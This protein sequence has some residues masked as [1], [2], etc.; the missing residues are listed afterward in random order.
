MFAYYWADGLSLRDPGRLSPESPKR[1]QVLHPEKILLPS[2]QGLKRSIEP[3]G[4]SVLLEIH[5]TKYVSFV[6][7]AA[8]RGQ[9]FLD[10]GDTVVTDNIYPD[11]LLAASSGI[12]ALEAMANEGIQRAFC[13]VRPPGH[14]A[15][16]M[17]AL[18]FCVFNNAAIAARFAQKILGTSRVLIVDWDVHPGNGTEEIFWSDPSVF[19]LSFHE[20]GIFAAAGSEDRIG[21]GAGKGFSRNVNIEPLATKEHYLE[22]YKKVLF[23]VVESYRPGLIII[24]A[25]FDAHRRDTVSR[26]KLE[27]ET[28]SEMTRILLDASLLSAKGRVLSLLEGGYDLIALENSVKAHCQ[29]M[30]EASPTMSFSSNT[31]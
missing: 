19:T 3:R 22:I 9:R 20:K 7:E 13:A 26:L 12:N 2:M 4:E 31:P 11:S 5:E 18:G 21:D 8:S 17:R 1:N 15:N 27:D 10:S 30:I 29:A 16:Q 23:E 25:G 6:K 14:H 28:F 24:S